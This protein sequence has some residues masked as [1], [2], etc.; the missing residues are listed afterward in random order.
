MLARSKP[1][2]QQKLHERER[3]REE[4]GRE[5]GGRREGEG[6]IENTY[7]HICLIKET[8]SVAIIHFGSVERAILSHTWAVSCCV[9]QLANQNQRYLYL[10]HLKDLPLSLSHFEE[11]L[12]QIENT[13]T[14]YC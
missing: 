7:C 1:L 6:M 13:I 5:E 12:L 8:L 4:G 9:Q 10:P 11:Q 3:G 14:G 2:V